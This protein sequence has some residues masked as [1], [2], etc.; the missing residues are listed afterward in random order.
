ML[1]AHL[2]KGRFKDKGENKMNTGRSLIKFLLVLAMTVAVFGSVHAASYDIKE[3]T[4]QVKSALDARRARFE[5][6]AALKAEGKIGENN[7]GYVEVFEAGSSAEEIAKAE[8]IDRATIYNAIVSQ[9]GLP[10]DQSSI[11]EKVFAQV[12]RDK[13]A[14]GDSIQ[15]ESGQWIKK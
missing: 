6:L 15:N 3:M 4:P 13:A 12:Q 8:N 1:A 10:A 7:H 11:V 9:N 2:F 14:A 5:K